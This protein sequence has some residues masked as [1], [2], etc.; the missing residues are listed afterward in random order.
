MIMKQKTRFEN[1]WN[2]V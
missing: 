1:S 2:T